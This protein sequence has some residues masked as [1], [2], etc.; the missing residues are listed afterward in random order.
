M[1]PILEI[2]T[3]GS[4]QARCCSFSL[5]AFPAILHSCPQFYMGFTEPRMSTPGGRFSP[6]APPSHAAAPS[7][8]AKKGAS[9]WARARPTP[10]QRCEGDPLP[11][12]QILLWVE[13]AGTCEALNISD[14]WPGASDLRD[15]NG[16]SFLVR[17]SQRKT[18]P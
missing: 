17:T 1:H 12:P 10:G 14:G 13:R 16:N 6:C 3:H 2:K 4:R 11:W 18:M 9:I 7:A 5:M 8:M 15:R